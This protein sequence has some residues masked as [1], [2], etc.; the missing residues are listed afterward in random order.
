LDKKITFSSIKIIFIAGVILLE[1]LAITLDYNL[2]VVPSLLLLPHLLSF[3][4]ELLL[5]LEG[6]EFG[7][8]LEL[9]GIMQELLGFPGLL[10]EVFMELGNGGYILA[11]LCNEIQMYQLGLGVR[12]LQLACGAIE[13]Q[14]L[15][16]SDLQK[17]E[18]QGVLTSGCN[19]SRI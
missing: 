17:S 8:L 15:L 5:T 4:R 6:V 18:A 1:L 12:D 7:A 13:R 10:E 11:E 14:N 3:Q 9:L 19:H 2:G 16:V